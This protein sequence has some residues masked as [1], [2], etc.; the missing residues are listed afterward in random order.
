MPAFKELP[1]YINGFKIIKDLGAIK[2]VTCI[3]PYRLCLAECKKC[4]K[5]FEARPSDLKRISSCLCNRLPSSMKDNVRLKNIAK[6][7]FKRCYNSK[8]IRYDR[9]GGRGIGIC[10]EWLSNRR[11]FFDWALANGYQDTLTI[12]RIDNDKD[13]SPENCRFVSYQ[14]QNQNSSA[15]VLTPDIVLKIR[16]EYPQLNY[17]LLAKKYSVNKSTIANIIR[18]KTWKN[19]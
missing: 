10:D 2:S 13:Y 11:N 16:S 17:S 1:E 7:M 5:H 3:R 14:I 8:S 6:D 12:D 19:I 15:C 4:F 9:Y 18:L